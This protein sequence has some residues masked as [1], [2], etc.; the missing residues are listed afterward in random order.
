MR[1]IEVSFKFNNKSCNS[2]LRR[3]NRSSLRFIFQNFNVIKTKHPLPL[4]ILT[5]TNEFFLIFTPTKKKLFRFWEKQNLYCSS[6][7]WKK[8][9]LLHCYIYT[10]SAENL[11][12]QIFNVTSKLMWLVYVFD[13]ENESIE[14]NHQVQLNFEKV[15]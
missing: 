15:L 7:Y 8:C 2:K 10:L 9:W 14:V 12:L 4:E 6:I 13:S 3:I 1:S 11:I 5:M